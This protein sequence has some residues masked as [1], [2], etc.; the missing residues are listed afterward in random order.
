[1]SGYQ[2]RAATRRSWNAIMSPIAHEIAANLVGNATKLRR[3][4]FA[5]QW[6]ASISHRVTDQD[7]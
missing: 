3:A 2:R 6:C 7:N 4:G 5:M 1:M